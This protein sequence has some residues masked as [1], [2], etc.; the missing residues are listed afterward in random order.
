MVTTTAKP[1]ATA[2]PACIPMAK[3]GESAYFSSERG[4]SNALSST[5]RAVSG[6]IRILAC[7]IIASSVCR[8]Q[9]QP[10]VIPVIRS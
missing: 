4:L 8:E 9:L 2:T 1:E 6:L 3:H 10:Y 5:V 7:I